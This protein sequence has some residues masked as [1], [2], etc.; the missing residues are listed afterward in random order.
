MLLKVGSIVYAKVRTSICDKGEKG[1][2][3]YLDTEDGEQIYGVVFAFGG[4][5]GFKP[6]EVKALLDF[7]GEVDPRMINYQYVD[8]DQS[9]IDFVH[10]VI[11]QVL[12]P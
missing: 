1:V 4:F 12:A 11:R 3:Y 5:D 9:T 6:K 7:Q 2:C 8:D 10:G